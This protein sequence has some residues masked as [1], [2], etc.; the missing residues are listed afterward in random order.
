MSSVR[1]ASEVPKGFNGS[2]GTGLTVVWS[3][4]VAIWRVLSGA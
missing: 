3:V 2:R 1:I 4:Q